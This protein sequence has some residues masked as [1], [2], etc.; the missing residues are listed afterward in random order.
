M[1]LRRVRAIA[2]KEFLQVWRDPRSLML[3]LLMPF[4]QMALLGYG[5][6]LDIKNVRMCAFD[7][8]S[9]P[10]S[11]ALLKR[12]QS[13]GY[14][15]IV[16]MENDYRAT[17]EALDYGRC[18]IAIVI[19][20]DFSLRINDSGATSVQ[21]L[22]DATDDNTAEIALG[23]AQ[24]IVAGFS[25]DV[26]LR[27][28][29]RRGR[30]LAEA[31]PVG[32][33]RVWY[34]ED[35]NSRN[36]IIPGVVAMVLALVGAQ[37]TS[38][39][40]AREWE[41]GTME[42]L[43]STPVSSRELMIGKLAPYFVIGLADAAFCLGMAVFWFDVPFRGDALTLTLTTSLYL[44]VVLGV[45][46]F[47]SVAIRSQIGASQ[48]ALLVTMLPTTLLSGFTFAIDQMPA[49]VQ[50][51]TYLVQARYY[52]TIVRSVFLKGVGLDILAPAILGLTVYALLVGYFASRAFKK[53]LV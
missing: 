37:L 15:Q 30:E 27:L 6:S 8:E 32:R 22:L 24:S 19:P 2:K 29:A 21:A 44:V 13:S 10:H 14:F 25:S 53:R 16:E 41:R 35:L 4:L 20:P 36:F 7:R 47:I 26:Q 39:T 23:Y 33:P 46:Y 12:F 9:G 43:I 48:I 50:A 5:L 42:V 34:N 38:L 18:V 11:E 3:A 40:I 1:K 49:P 28:E 51:L 45:G 31:P 52:V 17:T